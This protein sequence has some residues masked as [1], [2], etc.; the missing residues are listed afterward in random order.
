MAHV[1][2]IWYICDICGV[3]DMYWWCV[4]DVYVS[5]V[6]YV[7]MIRTAILTNSKCMMYILK[8]CNLDEVM[9]KKWMTINDDMTAY[10]NDSCIP[11]KCYDV[12]SHPIFCCCCCCCYCCC[13][14]IYGVCTHGAHILRTR[15]SSFGTLKRWRQRFN[16]IVFICIRWT[17]AMI[18]NT[19]VRV[20]ML[21][22]NFQLS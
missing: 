15:N 2:C 8:M 20:K 11:I 12:Y 22:F 17:Y 3:C 21:K 4:Y 13:C 10:L 5:Y 1:K 18:C 6:I 7:L 16:S 9:N 19:K 14:C